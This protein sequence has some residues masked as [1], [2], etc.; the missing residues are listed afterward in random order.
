MRKSGSCSV[1]KRGKF[2]PFFWSE[3]SVWLRALCRY[4]ADKAICNVKRSKYIP[5]WLRRTQPDLKPVFLSIFHS[6]PPLSSATPSLYPSLRDRVREDHL[7]FSYSAGSALTPRWLLSLGKAGGEGEKKMDERRRRK[8]SSKD[9]GKGL[10]Y[11]REQRV[12]MRRD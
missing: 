10:W 11:T 7:T 2:A 4:R 3:W 9:G 6:S 5:S 1:L 12:E 8:K